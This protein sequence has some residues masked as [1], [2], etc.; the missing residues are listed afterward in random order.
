M[1]ILQEFTLI[2][3]SIPPNLQEKCAFFHYFGSQINPK[4]EMNAVFYFL[5]PYSGADLAR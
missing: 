3:G 1:V 5:E 2:L 4:L